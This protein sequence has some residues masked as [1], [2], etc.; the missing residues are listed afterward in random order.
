MDDITNKVTKPQAA[1]SIPYTP[2]IPHGQLSNRLHADDRHCSPVQDAS[3][4]MSECSYYIGSG[5]ESWSGSQQALDVI[6][7]SKKRHGLA[8]ND[9]FSK[10]LLS[11]NV[12]SVHANASAD[13]SDGSR[14]ANSCD[15]GVD[16][17]ATPHRLTSHN[18]NSAQNYGAVAS[19]PEIIKTA[20]T[21]IK[22]NYDA[23]GDC[24]ARTPNHAYDRHRSVGTATPADV[25]IS[26]LDDYVTFINQDEG[27]TSASVKTHAQS[28]PKTCHVDEQQVTQSWKQMVSAA[29]LVSGEYIDLISF[30][31]GSSGTRDRLPSAELCSG[32][33]ESIGQLS[34]IASS[35]YQSFGY[36]QSNSPIDPQMTQ[37]QQQPQTPQHPL[38][39]A[40]PLFN[41]TKVTPRSASRTTRSPSLS[42]LSSND[43]AKR[44]HHVSRHQ[45]TKDM[46]QPAVPVSVATCR[47]LA[48]LSSS[49][50][51]LSQLDNTVQV[52]DRSQ[53]SLVMTTS[54]FPS[55]CPSRISLPPDSCYP[56]RLNAYSELSKSVE[57]SP[58][59]DGDTGMKRTVT[60]S[61]LSDARYGAASPANSLYANMKMRSNSAL[62]QNTVRMGVRSVQHKKQEQEKTKAEVS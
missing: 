59:P 17:V 11:D 39:F 4:S 37:Q 53:S 2:S 1:P 34:A 57:F 25:K 15:R 33:Q 18:A 10:Y 41:L 54:P 61:V 43:S 40:N 55:P 16:T 60:D 3:V 51:S 45:C 35:G 19:E 5:S 52:Q 24:L 21:N 48:A 8:A 50:E 27:R 14:L 26:Q 7:E 58:V 49:G 30:I 38:S 31:D 22:K 46:H 36:S 9:A 23:A 20:F 29:D 32:D 6:S 12:A 56:E 13:F 44:S 28:T 42:S 62:P 47:S